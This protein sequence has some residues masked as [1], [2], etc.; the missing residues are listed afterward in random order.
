MH[1]FLESKILS[2]TH[3]SPVPV[4]IILLPEDARRVSH[5]HA[6]RRYIFNH[7]TPHP[8]QAAASYSQL[9]ANI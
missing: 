7:H 5:H 2:L 3:P 8:Y 6:A 1:P 9:L 4:G